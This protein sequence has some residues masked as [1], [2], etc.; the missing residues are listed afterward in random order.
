[1]VAREYVCIL[2]NNLMFNIKYNASKLG[3]ET[4]KIN[5]CEFVKMLYSCCACAA[6]NCNF[7]NACANL[8]KRL[9]FACTKSLCVIFIYMRGQSNCPNHNRMRL[10]ANICHLKG[11]FMI[12]ASWGRPAQKRPPHCTVRMVPWVC[13][14]LQSACS[15]K[16]APSIV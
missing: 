9:K 11:Q 16:W 4:V 12:S 7:V 14:C 3:R 2:F 8:N 13:M 5:Y 1:M 6:G 10:Q 15:V